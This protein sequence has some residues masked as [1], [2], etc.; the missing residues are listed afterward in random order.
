MIPLKVGVVAEVQKQNNAKEKS[1]LPPVPTWEKTKDMRTKAF[2]S[3]RQRWV[4]K[5]T[6]RGTGNLKLGLS[7]MLQYGSVKS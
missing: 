1:E 4:L 3:R 2:D 5:N 7:Q 6:L